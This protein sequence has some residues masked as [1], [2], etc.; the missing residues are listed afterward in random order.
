MPSEAVQATGRAHLCSDVPLR[1]RGR[2]RKGKDDAVQQESVATDAASARK[3][4]HRHK[5]PSAAPLAVAPAPTQAEAW[6]PTSPPQQTGRPAHTP[7]ARSTQ[8]QGPPR[9]QPTHLPHHSARSGGGAG[10]QL[11]SDS[12]AAAG[13]GDGGATGEDREVLSKLNLLTSMVEMMAGEMREMRRDHDKLKTKLRKVVGKMKDVK[14]KQAQA[15]IRSSL[16]FAQI[17]HQHQ[18]QYQHQ[19]HNY[20]QPHHNQQQ[21]SHGQHHTQQQQQNEWQATGPLPRKRQRLAYDDEDDYE[22]EVVQMRGYGYGGGSGF[23]E[24]QQQQQR[25]GLGGD[26]GEAEQGHHHSTLVPLPL[27]PVHSRSIVEEVGRFAPFLAQYNVSEHAFAVR[28]LS[29]PICVIVFRSVY[30]PAPPLLLYANSAFAD[31][32][33]YSCGEL[34]GSPIHNIC[35]PNRKLTAQFASLCINQKPMS[36]SVV[37]FMTPLF[38][39]RDGRMLRTQQ[40]VQFFYDAQG[41]VKYVLSNLLDWRED[42]LRDGEELGQWLPLAD[43]LPVSSSSPASDSSS[44]SPIPAPS[45]SSSSAHHWPRSQPPAP[46]ATTWNAHTASSAAVEEA[47]G[48]HQTFQHMPATNHQPPLAQHHSHHQHHHHRQYH[49]QTAAP[50]AAPSPPLS[51]FSYPPPSTSPWHDHFL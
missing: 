3:A 49:Y 12:A 7:Q 40:N 9:P 8:A 14:A 31:L 22:D 26:S 48:H 24:Q 23:E 13:S 19:Q 37:Y 46:S 42:Q 4:N 28:D 17:Q 25:R 1:K 50:M 51:D 32:L 35:V 21:H 41:H 47:R 27:V 6:T 5:T 29:R 20:N 34:V 15:D 45:P 11:E 18:H 10:G 36:A 16:A 38:R 2:P 44:P 43:F 39:R 30:D 33:S